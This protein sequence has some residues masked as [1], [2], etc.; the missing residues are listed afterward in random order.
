M[1]NSNGERQRFHRP[2]S[3]GGYDNSASGLGTPPTWLPPKKAGTGGGPAGPAGPPGLT[4][5]TGPT[6]PPGP[7][8]TPGA[9]GVGV[10]VPVVNGQWIKGVG[11]AAV[12]API[13]NP[14]LPLILTPQQVVASQNASGAAAFVANNLAAN[15]YILA[16]MVAGDANLRF[17]LDRNGAITWGPGNAAGDTSL[18][19]AAAGVLVTGGQFVSNQNAAGN[20]AFLAA[21]L[22][23]DGYGLLVSRNG[24][25]VFRFLLDQSGRMSW[26]PGNAAPDTFLSRLASGLL[27]TPTAFTTGAAQGVYGYNAVGA[28]TYA[29][30]GGTF[31]SVRATNTGQSHTAAVLGDAGTFRWAV[32]VN[33]V[34]QWADGTIA[35]PDTNLYRARASTLQTDSFFG[36]VGGLWAN[37]TIWAERTSVGQV[38]YAAYLTPDAN[39]RFEILADGTL[40][41]GDGTNALDTT[42][43]RKAPGV[44][45]VDDT[46]D[47]NALTINGA[48]IS[49]TGI[50]PRLGPGGANVTDCNLA[51]SNGWWYAW[52]T[53]ANLPASGTN[54]IIRVDAYDSV[55]YLWQTAYEFGSGLRIWQRFFGVGAWQPW[56]QTWPVG[57][58]GGQVTIAVP[59]TPSPEG[60][61]VA[62]F[63]I[64]LPV[65]WPTSHKSFVATGWPQVTW[66]GYSV[67]GAEALD[68]GHG[69]VA[70]MNTTGA[71][72]VVINW[73]SY[74]N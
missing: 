62:A 50:P 55:N 68:N 34:M 25:S 72:N 17:V 24:D 56:T 57:T 4:G 60:L 51:T 44:L 6:G 37:N 43:Y 20:A 28:G 27:N 7:A 23:A 70:I 29:G 74:G 49:E 13:Q 41:W 22:A 67:M 14:D 12:W 38:A 8:G 59:V 35:S 46:L 73:I 2:G 32:D 9:P 10:P 18:Y 45:R 71:Q 31:G 21:N 3:A 42:L 53:A 19:R 64:T 66:V 15:G 26:G 1:S 36:A 61:P 54:V 47:A 30:P 40:R 33:G 52:N 39:D 63:S 48:A 11:G 5:P 16:G 58:Q 65:A 69:Q